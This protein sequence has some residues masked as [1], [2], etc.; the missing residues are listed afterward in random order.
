MGFRYLVLTK[1]ALRVP[2]GEQHSK[3]LPDF[4]I[5]PNFIISLKE[6]QGV[7][8]EKVADVVEILIGVASDLDSRDVHR[9]REGA[10]A[11][12]SPV[13]RDDGAVCWRASLQVGTPSAR[14]IHYWALP[15]GRIELSRVTLHD[16]FNP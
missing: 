6:L 15:K 4:D 16:D 7:S 1:W 8:E 10:G 11:L 5:G 13:K 3:P 12:E 14:R 9:L 2:L